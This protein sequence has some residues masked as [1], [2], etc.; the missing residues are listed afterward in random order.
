MLLYE[1]LT[2]DAGV[3][4][5]GED[6]P[7]KFFKIF[8]P[9]TTPFK[10]G[11]IVKIGVYESELGSDL[12]NCFDIDSILEYNPGNHLRQVAKAATVRVR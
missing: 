11:F 9:F 6:F 10:V 1:C 4:S 8:A 2:S 5:C 3:I 12:I 7:G